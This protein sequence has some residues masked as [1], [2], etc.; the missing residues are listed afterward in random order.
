MIESELQL[1]KREMTSE[2]IRKIFNIDYK[3][4]VMDTLNLVGFFPYGH[5]L[6]FFDTPKRHK[7][8]EAL[9]FAEE[10][11]GEHMIFVSF[12][13]SNGVTTRHKHQEPIRENYFQ[14]AGSSH[15]RLGDNLHELK[16][17][18]TL[19]VPSDTFHQLTTRENPSLVLIVM[20]NAIS[21]PR[22]RLHIPVGI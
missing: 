11:V 3:R 13:D 7:G 15:L 14:L 10:M 22:D 4:L 18:S 17:G 2:E 9:Y 21:V 16:A 12:L 8:S 1:G 20:E 6:N 19:T 5:T